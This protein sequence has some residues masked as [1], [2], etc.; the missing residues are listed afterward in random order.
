MQT[1]QEYGRHSNM[2]IPASQVML[3]DGFEEIK[4]SSSERSAQGVNKKE[5]RYHDMIMLFRWGHDGKPEIQMDMRREH[6]KAIHDSQNPILFLVAMSLA[7]RAFKDCGTIDEIFNLE[8]PHYNRLILEWVTHMLQLPI[9][10]VPTYPGPT[11]AIQEPS[12]FSRQVKKAAQLSYYNK[13]T[14]FDFRGE[15]LTRTS[16]EILI[17]SRLPSAN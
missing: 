17:I 11:R 4:P 3:S 8:V 16:S 12:L 10:K 5:L 7:S 2:Q 1:P 13:I 14:A 15:G 6:A 9:S